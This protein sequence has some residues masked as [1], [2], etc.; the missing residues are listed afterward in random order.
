MFFDSAIL[1]THT[2]APFGIQ[3]LADLL[4]TV[5]RKKTDSKGLTK[6]AQGI[7]CMERAFNVREGI[8]RK[9]DVL[10]KRILTG[11]ISELPDLRPGWKW[12]SRAK[13]P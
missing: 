1:C 3:M 8:G 11:G 10:P 6:A 7:S 13:I 2:I 5:T 4:T 12:H 9:D